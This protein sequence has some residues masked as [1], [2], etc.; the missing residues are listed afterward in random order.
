MTKKE[1][2]KNFVKEHKEDIIRFS[3]YALGVGVGIGICKLKS[4]KKHK[5]FMKDRTVFNNPNLTVSD[6]GKVGEEMISKIDEVTKDTPV[7]NWH[8]G[9]LEK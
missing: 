1:K 3:Y 9:Y 7:K 5:E 6:F 2:V 8:I 4:V